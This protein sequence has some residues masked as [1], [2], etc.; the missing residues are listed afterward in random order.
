MFSNKK[1]I[2]FGLSA[3]LSASIHAENSF[4]LGDDLQGNLWK[5]TN[6][7]ASLG[8]TPPTSYLQVEFPKPLHFRN[9]HQIKAALISIRLLCDKRDVAID[10]IKLQDGAGAEIANLSASD[11]SQMY[12]HFL[13]ETI[14]NSVFAHSCTVKNSALAR[15]TLAD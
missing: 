6:N 13:P 10:H 2:L 5:I 11:P 7:Q 14:K 8:K 12:A 4:E 3:L 15:D 9:H 1:M